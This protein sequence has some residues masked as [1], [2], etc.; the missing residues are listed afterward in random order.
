MPF[1]HYFL[2]IKKAL[3]PSSSLS[4]PDILRVFGVKRILSFSIK[5]NTKLSLRQRFKPFGGLSGY[6]SKS[7]N[8]LG[9]MQAEGKKPIK[10]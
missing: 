1:I 5:R 10:K 6:H 4:V 3:K 2:G 9:L 7:I 8:I